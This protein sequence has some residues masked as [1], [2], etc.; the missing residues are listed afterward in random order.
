VKKVRA[1]KSVPGAIL[2]SLEAWP[3]PGWAEARL[4]WGGLVDT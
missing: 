1:R 4:G 2:F 3:K